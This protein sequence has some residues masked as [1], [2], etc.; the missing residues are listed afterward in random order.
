MDT[1]VSLPSDLSLYIHIPFC[2]KKCDYCPFFSKANQSS[3]TIDLFF[4]SLIKEL[5]QI[6]ERQEAPF[7]T[8]FI[9]GGNPGLLGSDKLAQIAHL[10][11]K[12]GA[13]KEFTIEMNPESLTDDMD[14]IFS[15]GVNRLSIGIQTLNEEHLHTLMRSASKEATLAALQ[16]TAYLHNRFNTSINVDIMTCIPGQTINESL[17]DIQQMISLSH[18]DHISLYNLT[19]EEGTNLSRRRNL[20][21]IEPIEEELEREFLLSLWQYLENNGFHQYEVSNFARNEVSECVH[22]KRYW[23]LENYIGVGPSAVGTYRYNGSV[24]RRTGEED[25]HLYCSDDDSKRYKSEILTKKEVLLEYLMV[26]LRKNEGIIK[27]HFSHRFNLEF[28]TL[29]KKELLRISQLFP[30]MVEN[31]HR[32]F[33]LRTEGL[34]LCDSFINLLSDAIW[35]SDDLLDR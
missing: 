5:K 12:K 21:E 28:D 9:G 13:V 32:E 26:S 29:F 34:L 14:I 20:A 1:L 23:K 17:N 22:N 16:R 8:V 24:T 11:T 25:I 33:S 27:S 10:V 2:I 35:E 4:V 15:S 19:F 31:T 30:N 7:E 6:V 18:I 3:A